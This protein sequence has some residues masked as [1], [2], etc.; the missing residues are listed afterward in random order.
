MSD[1]ES[2]A[3]RTLQSSLASGKDYNELDLLVLNVADR[4]AGENA[5][6]T[7]AQNTLPFRIPDLSE[8]IKKVGYTGWFDGDKVLTTSQRIDAIGNCFVPTILNSQLGGLSFARFVASLHEESPPWKL[9]AATEFKE[10][11]D[12][13]KKKV[14]SKTCKAN[15]KYLVRN[16]IPYPFP[17]ELLAQ[18]LLDLTRFSCRPSCCSC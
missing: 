1:F 16:I 2:R 13:I 18:R 8:M 6:N 12:N 11:W 10:L 3:F 4:L 17:N 5:S 14:K 15:K 9:P 7:P